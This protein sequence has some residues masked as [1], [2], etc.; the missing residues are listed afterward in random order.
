MRVSAPRLSASLLLDLLLVVAFAAIGRRSH[1]ETGALVGV[2]STAWPF[3]VGSL[4]GWGVALAARLVPTTVRGGVPVWLCTVAVGMLLRVVT[5]AGTA[6]SFV[7][8]A[9]TALAILLL[10]PRVVVERSQRRAG[11]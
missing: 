6:F 2:L 7:L 4:V 10:L 3:L 11:A 8:V 9:T 5:G 1:A